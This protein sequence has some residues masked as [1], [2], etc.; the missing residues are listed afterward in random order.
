MLRRVWRQAVLVALA[1]ALAPASL[2]VNS[3]RV[4]YYH[5]DA[6]GN[7]RVVTDENGHVIERHDYLPFGEEC[8][9]GA[10]TANPSGA[11][12]Q[13]RRFTGKE[14]DD[15]T[16][17]DAF[18][19][20]YYAQHVGRFTTV[21][22]V[23]AW[24][25]NLLDPQ[26]WNRYAYGRN[27]PLR[28]VDPDGRNPIAIAI[29][30]AAAFV[31]NNPTNA[32]V[33]TGPSHDTII[34]NSVIVAGGYGLA[35]GGARLAAQEVLQETIENA[36]GL[37]VGG[38]PSLRGTNAAGKLTSRGSFRKATVQDAWDNARPGADGGRLCPTCTAEVTVAPFSGKPR[39]WDV[40]HDP[41][42]T[43]R[44]FPANATRQQ[45]LDDYQK[46]TGLE[47]PGCNRGRGD[48]D[49]RRDR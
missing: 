29:V 34:P 2:A 22:P 30:L 19:A 40:S 36:T 3:G 16:G 18:G 25:E 45:V 28:Y 32:N 44:E 39:D 35:A 4:E 48:R 7:V 42:W 43:K 14:R 17:L 31:L 33:T 12:G 13:P 38:I 10:C 41:S 11:G 47:C 5:R 49:E 9:T 26:R 27:N 24:R 1:S 6:L 20:R 21:D 23:Y 8:A 37:P 15:E 46:G